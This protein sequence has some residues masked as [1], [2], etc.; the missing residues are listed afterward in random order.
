[1]RTSSQLRKT[2]T[3]EYNPNTKLNSVSPVIRDAGVQKGVLLRLL[4]G[5][6]IDNIASELES[7]YT[8][9]GKIWETDAQLTGTLMLQSKRIER[10]AKWELTSQNRQNKRFLK[11]LTADGTNPIIVSLRGENIEA[12]PDYI[13]ENRSRVYVCKV[14]TGRF[15]PDP[16]ESVSSQEALALGLAGEKLYPDKEVV[17]Q[18]LYLG[19]RNDVA[20]RTSLALM[21]DI[22]YDTTDTKYNKIME[23]IFNREM[24]QEIQTLYE[25]EDH[26]CK[27]EDC[28]ACSMNNI[29]NYTEAPIPAPASDSVRPLGDIRLSHDQEAAYDHGTARVNAGPG[30]GKTLVTSLHFERLIEK[31]YDPKKFCLLTF[32]NAGAGEMTARTIAYAAEK[33]HPVDP[34]NLTS[35]T[36]NAFCQMIIDDNYEQLG[37]TRKPRVIDDA[38]KRGLI[39]RILDQFPR[40]TNW[41]YTGSAAT[42]RVFR[43][44][45]SSIAYI[46]ASREFEEIKKEGYT[47][48]NYP[49][50]W[51]KTYS[52][53]E[54]RILFM[55]YDEFNHQL[56]KKNYLEFDD[57]IKYIEQLSEANPDLFEQLGYEHIVVDEF[58]DTDYP[59]IK[60]LQKLRDTTCFK[61][62]MCVGDDCFPPHV[63]GIHGKLQ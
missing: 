44:D 36:F 38:S 47:K 15:R 35:T 1:M 58:Q 52:P 12:R 37:F 30:S 7:S 28:A 22:P 34:D 56:K 63:T 48:D 16:T 18:Y 25:N 33:S 53:D 3:C 19:D 50:I 13:V 24:K 9:E 43:K 5:E 45:S 17:V 57:Q 27:P 23:R 29:C 39:N 40:M 54:I 21:D 4:R 2:D 6:P 31:G 59:Q 10:L 61:S 55:M 26:T 62:L 49:P 60:L 46:R 51:D 41:T 32:T 42:E 11:D 8:R 14:K 20:E